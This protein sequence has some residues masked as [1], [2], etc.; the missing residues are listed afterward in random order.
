MSFWL[1]SLQSRSI[2]VMT[3]DLERDF[4]HTSGHVACQGVGQMEMEMGPN[5]G[6]T[7]IAA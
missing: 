6:S 5:E 2:H 1:M 3:H 7:S 4:T